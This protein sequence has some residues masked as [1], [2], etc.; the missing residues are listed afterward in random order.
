MVYLIIVFLIHSF[1]IMVI[2]EEKHW[3]SYLENFK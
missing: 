3:H 1:K 2:Q